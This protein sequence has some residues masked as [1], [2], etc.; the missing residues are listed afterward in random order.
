MMQ[1]WMS[2][3]LVGRC[4]WRG[5][6]CGLTAALSIELMVAGGSFAL[7][8]E[9]STEDQEAKP[10]KPEL[11]KSRPTS[12]QSKP[13][14]KDADQQNHAGST[15]GGAGRAKTPLPERPARTVTPPTLTSAELDR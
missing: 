8:F 4:L 14:A 7:S 13:L 10:A 12:D 5:F 2:N 6:V 9:P 11:G 15:P 3:R 1:R